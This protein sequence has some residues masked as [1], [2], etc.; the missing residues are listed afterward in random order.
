M[1]NKRKEKKR[2]E[3]NPIKLVDRSKKYYNFLLLKINPNR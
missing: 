2:K 3:K 1:N